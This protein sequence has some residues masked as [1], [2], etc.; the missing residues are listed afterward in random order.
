VGGPPHD[1][2]KRVSSVL[3]L[4]R[5]MPAITVTTPKATSV[6]PTRSMTLCFAPRAKA[7]RAAGNADNRRGWIR[8]RQEGVST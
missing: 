4:S 8:A 7:I 3:P 6:V 2:H 5:A 1:D